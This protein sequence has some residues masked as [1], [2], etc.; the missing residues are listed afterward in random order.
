MEMEERKRLSKLHFAYFDRY[1]NLAL[2]EIRDTPDLCFRETE[3]CC[4]DHGTITIG[5]AH[6]FI[7]EAESEKEFI[8]AVLYLLGHEMQHDLCSADK[9]WKYGISKGRKN[10]Y[11]GLSKIFEGAPRKFLKDADYDRFVKDMAA[12]KIF[13]TD[14]LILQFVH[15]IQ[16]SLEDGRIERIRARDSFIFADLRLYFRGKFWFSGKTSEPI[17]DAERLFIT[18]TN[19]VLAY[20]TTGLPQNGYPDIATKASDEIV[21]SLLRNIARGVWSPSCQ[22]CMDEALKVEEKLLPVLAEAIRLYQEPPECPPV[23][24]A[25]NR[26][27]TSRNEQIDTSQ[28]TKDAYDQLGEDGSGQADGGQ[29]GDQDGDQAG[30]DVGE[31]V[32]GNASSAGGQTADSNGDGASAESDGIMNQQAKGHGSST[33]EFKMGPTALLSKR[34][35][36]D[37]V[38]N[39]VSDHDAVSKAIRDAMEKAATGVLAAQAATA[40]SIMP[41]KPDPSEYVTDEEAVKQA[42]RALQERY[43]S[44]DVDTFFEEIRRKYSLDDPLPA[45]LQSEAD[46]FAREVEK[47]FIRDMTP[48][49]KGMTSGTIDPTRLWHLATHQFDCFEKKQQDKIREKAVY[50]LLDNSGS[51]G[52]GRESKRWHACRA[53]SIIEEGFKKHVPIKIVAFDAQGCTHVTHE[54]IKGWEERYPENCSYNFLGLGRSGCGNKDGYSIRIAT[55][56]LLARPEDDKLLIVMS[57]GTPSAYSMKANPEADVRCAVQEARNN[58]IRVVG[59]FFADNWKS[60]E[61]AK[62]FAAM[63][64]QDFVCTEPTQI[65]PELIR[66]LK[67]FVFAK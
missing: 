33:G 28:E 19:Q 5:L 20:A 7:A 3:G 48:S 4:T 44:E 45:A 22:Q 11:I 39:T 66:V 13:F 34:N 29:A 30:G 56:E 47:L 26:G 64:G 60:T 2:A 41:K 36:G 54:V 17:T 23:P 42:S 61:E 65:T 40:M 50:V 21:N 53:L 51:M 46:T 38:A 9:A 25:G 14:N 57:D 49:V 52:Y 32:G 12:Q 59:I 27:V 8:N 37:H 58:G 62:A 35:I 15:G 6:P 1:K 67:S 55:E 63:Y 43:A 16:N 10:A 18:L 24:A 31:D